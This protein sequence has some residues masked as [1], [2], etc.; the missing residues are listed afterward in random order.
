M[1]NKEHRLQG[2]KDSELTET[3]IR[4]AIDLGKRLDQINFHTIYSSPITRAAK[5]ADLICSGRPIPIVFDDGLKELNFG[6][7][8]GKTKKDIEKNFQNEYFNLFHAPHMYNHEPHN[9]ESLE[10]FKQRVEY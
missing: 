5:T 4:N 2:W 10:D 7:W 8:E 3:G 9:G 6:E 1:W